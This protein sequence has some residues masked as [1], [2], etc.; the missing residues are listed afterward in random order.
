MFGLK[1]AIL[2]AVE[3]DIFPRLKS[4]LYDKRNRKSSLPNQAA[5]EKIF[6][7]SSAS[8]SVWVEDSRSANEVTKYEKTNTLFRS[9]AWGM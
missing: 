4:R 3:D 2:Y 9:L 6:V 8:V 1:R 5:L 7:I